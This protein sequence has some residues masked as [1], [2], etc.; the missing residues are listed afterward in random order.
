[1]RLNTMSDKVHAVENDIRVTKIGSFM[2][3]TSID[4]LPQFLNVLIGNMSVVGPRP[5]TNNTHVTY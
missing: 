2:R 1:M 3:K 4:E 5:R